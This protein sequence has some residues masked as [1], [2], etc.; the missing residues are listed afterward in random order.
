MIILFNKKSFL[1]PNK[2]LTH[3][4][5]LY[6]QKVIMRIQGWKCT[7][8]VNYILYIQKIY[9]FFAYMQIFQMMQFLKMYI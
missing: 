8:N 3:K 7:P 9:I 1:P 5:A 2:K 6:H 4:K